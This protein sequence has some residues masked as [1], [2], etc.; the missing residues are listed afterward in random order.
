MEK[1]KELMEAIKENSSKAKIAPK[2]VGKWIFK[3]GQPSLAPK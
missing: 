2:V 3:E 1:L